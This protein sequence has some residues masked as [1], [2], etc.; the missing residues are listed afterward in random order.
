MDEQLKAKLK[1]W[2]G[3]YNVRSFISMIRFSFLIGLRRNG[4]SKYPLLS[5]PGSL[6]DA[7]N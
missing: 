4:I 3:I 2:A 5:L 7:G 6:M 1:E